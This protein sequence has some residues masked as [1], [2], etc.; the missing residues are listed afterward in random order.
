VCVCP[1]L[2]FSVLV[3]RLSTLAYLGIFYRARLKYE[4][5]KRFP[6]VPNEK[7]VLSP[8]PQSSDDLFRISLTV[9]EDR[10]DK[11]F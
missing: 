9:G 10:L 3:A 8:T 6:Q 11:I 1:C 4:L 7:V 5:R 2:G